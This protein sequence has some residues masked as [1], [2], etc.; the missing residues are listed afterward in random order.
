LLAGVLIYHLLQLYMSHAVGAL[1]DQHEQAAHVQSTQLLDLVPNQQTVLCLSD[2][3][4]GSSQMVFTG[5]Q[6]VCLASQM[7][8][9]DWQALSPALGIP[10]HQAK[11]EKGGTGP[12]EFLHGKHMMSLDRPE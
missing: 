6:P 9:P 12:P 1:G 10:P 7:G 11:S 8:T 2:A 4:P 5:F 3:I